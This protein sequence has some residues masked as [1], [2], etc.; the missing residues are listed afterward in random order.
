M[1]KFAK[2]L[3]LPLLVAA[4]V[5]ISAPHALAKTV[6]SQQHVA[7]KTSKQADANKES[8]TQAGKKTANQLVS[9]STASPSKKTS[10][11]STRHTKKKGANYRAA[12]KSAANTNSSMKK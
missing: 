3:L 8:T 6:A 7:L 12:K 11:R 10:A 1:N 2:A 4:P 5:A 9:Q